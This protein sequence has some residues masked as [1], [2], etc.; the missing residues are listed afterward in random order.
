MRRLNYILTLCCTLLLSFGCDR[1]A[2]PGLPGGEEII[3][4]NG[5]PYIYLDAMVDK[6]TRAEVIEGTELQEDFGAYG[7]TYD[8]TNRWS[9]YR[10]TATP[11]VFTDDGGTF[12]APQRVTYKGGVYS[13]SPI[14]TWE[15]GKYTFFAYYPSNNASVEPS[16]VDV[17]GTPYVVYAPANFLTSTENHADVMTAMFEDTSLSSSQYVDFDF[18]HRL[19]AVEVAAMNF[20]MY[21]YEESGVFKSEKITIEITDLKVVFTNLDYKAA[22]FYL[23]SS[24]APEPVANDGTP[25]YV[26]VDG[27]KEISYNSNSSFTRVAE[28]KVMLFIP[29]ENEDLKVTTTVTYQKRRPDNSLL[30]ADPDADGITWNEANATYTAEKE[31]KFGQALKPGSRYYIQVTFTSSAVSIN[32]VT[33]AEWEDLSEDV[34]HEFE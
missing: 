28:D 34:R 5:G 32:I 8:F 3:L 13:Y 29:Q 26:I 16:G 17:K 22:K 20:Y 24:I 2:V 14:K 11:N 1:E 7:F 27:M 15:G 18:E 30:N 25:S 23:D 12:I 31:T 33:S 21:D 6:S 19:S 9:T 10:I 4:P